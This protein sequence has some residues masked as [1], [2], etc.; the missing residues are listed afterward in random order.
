MH[1]TLGFLMACFPNVYW[2]LVVKLWNLFPRLLHGNKTLNTNALFLFPL[3]NRDA[4][5][6]H[7]YIFCFMNRTRNPFWLCLHLV[8][9]WQCENYF[10]SKSVNVKAQTITCRDQCF[11]FDN[12]SFL[13]SKYLS[14][15]NV[16]GTILG[17]GAQRL[18]SLVSVLK[19][20]IL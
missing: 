15:Y 18:V 5:I 9:F 19:Y 7:T 16:L 4:F 12:N 8:R 11:A 2:N 20:L 1:S 6:F 10:L 17:P 14:P 13:H 3:F